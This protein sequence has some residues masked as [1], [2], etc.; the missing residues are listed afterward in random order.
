MSTR[1]ASV[2][3]TAAPSNHTKKTSTGEAA[4]AVT[5]PSNV[6]LYITNLRLLNLDKLPDWPHITAQTFSTKDVQQS[7]KNRIRC[8]EWSLFRLF[9]L[10]DPEETK[11]KLQPFFPA[12]EPLQ[13]LNLRAALYR[14]LNDIKK[15]GVLGRDSVLRKSMLDECKGDK[16]TDILVSFSTAVLG[17]KLFTNKKSRK[18]DST[19]IKLSTASSLASGDQDIL[20]PLVIAHKVSLTNRLKQKQE[21]TARYQ[22][23]AEML[24]IKREQI[25]RRHEQAKIV[26]GNEPIATSKVINTS[27]IKRQIRD[28]WLG[29]PEWLEVMIHGDEQQQG[30]Q[31]LSRSFGEVWTAINKGETIEPP[32]ATKGL[33]ADLEARVKQQQRRL[34]DWKTFHATVAK[35]NSRIGAPTKSPTDLPTQSIT[36]DRHQEH[37]IADT[38]RTASTEETHIDIRS[39]QTCSQYQHIL[40]SMEAALQ[41]ASQPLQRREISPIPT[42]FKSIS[43]PVAR[44]GSGRL[45]AGQELFQQKTNVRTQSRNIVGSEIPRQKTNGNSQSKSFIRNAAPQLPQVH[46]RIVSA[47]AQSQDEWEDIDSS[48]I[49]SE[50]SSKSTFSPLQPPSLTE[51]QF[52]PD[53]HLPS[54]PPELVRSP[55]SPFIAIPSGAQQGETPPNTPPRA[56]HPLL[57]PSPLNTETRLADH[58]IS[59]LTAPTPSPT[60]HA[61]GVSSLMERTRM[62]IARVSLAPQPISDSLPSPTMEETPGTDPAPIFPAA[63]FNRRA[64]LLERT[65]LSMSMMSTQIQQQVRLEKRKSLAASKRQS[66]YPVNQFETPRKSVGVF[67][68][69]DE[70]EGRTTPKEALFEQDADAE[71]VFKSRPKIAISPVGTPVPILGEHKEDEEVED[72]IGW[73]PSK[74]RGQ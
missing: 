8:V 73:S 38:G 4:T 53:R 52:S 42:N 24:E 32:N 54:S 18:H 57:S 25:R 35:N 41:K 59:S 39:N 33:L 15:N 16:F 60:K 26:Y 64:S 51:N 12:L 14:C 72:S 65:R 27:H 11:N 69:E 61:P 21:K 3:S 70:E 37:R 48:E 30:D 55:Q 66:L 7:Q 36:F 67:R 31:F 29:N 5:R 74:G 23:L 40:Q 13:S 47:S 43:V 58:I 68:E 56:S 28:N 6:T 49:I 62:S 9:E 50:L 1:S 46:Q 45:R 10:W 71:S 2:A 44:N 20:L 17:R 34:D 22:D 19:A 63:G